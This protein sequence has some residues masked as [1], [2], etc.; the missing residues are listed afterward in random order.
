[1]RSVEQILGNVGLD[2]ILEIK[3]FELL[4][5][6]PFAVFPSTFPFLLMS[7]FDFDHMFQG[8][9]TGPWKGQR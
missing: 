2:R 8:L 5:A 7:G 1:M 6:S 3:E 9:Q 4:L